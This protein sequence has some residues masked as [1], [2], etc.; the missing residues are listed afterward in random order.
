M[1]E[2]VLDEEF[3]VANVTNPLLSLG[4]LLKRGWIFG[5]KD[6]KD[7]NFIN[8]SMYG[9]CAGM[10]IAPDKKCRIPV[11]YKRNSLS[12]LACVRRV[13]EEETETKTVCGVTVSFSMDVSKL[14]E[15]WQFLQNGSPCH[16]Q[17]VGISMI[18]RTRLVHLGDVEPR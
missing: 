7:G 1:D 9:P 5:A 2:C 12:I 16:V 10:L 8:E 4:R 13:E 6:D 15:G 17:L 18:S 14:K 3:V 11:F